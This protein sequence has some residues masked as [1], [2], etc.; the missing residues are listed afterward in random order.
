MIC[1]SVGASADTQQRV[2]TQTI[3]DS[4]A[5]SF[6]EDCRSYLT[7]CQIS[8]AICTMIYQACIAHRQNS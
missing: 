3:N 7:N 1:S 5:A 4:Q 6:H 8:P 2:F